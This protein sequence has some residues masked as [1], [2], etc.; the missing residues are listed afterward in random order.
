M[1]GIPFTVCRVGS[2]GIEEEVLY[3]RSYRKGERGTAMRKAL[4]A[5]I[6]ATF[7]QNSA[8]SKA[9]ICLARAGAMMKDEGAAHLEEKLTAL[10]I[11][12]S[13]EMEFARLSAD[14]ALEAAEVVAEISLQENYGERINEIMDKLTS[15]EIRAICDTLEQGAMPKDFFQFLDTLRRQSGTGPTTE[16]TAK[17]S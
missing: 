14:A 7:D 9:G 3:L 2:E 10:A 17:P 16:S 1:I 13:K 11:E 12:Q 5:Y 4:R 15:R 8:A 6:K